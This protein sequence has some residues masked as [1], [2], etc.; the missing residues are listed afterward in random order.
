MCLFLP[1]LPCM[2][3]LKPWMLLYS[4]K[5]AIVSHRPLILPPQTPIYF[6]V[7][8]TDLDTVLAPLSYAILEF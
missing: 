5:V 1:Y 2:P 3:L 4:A 8:E 6:T 7:K